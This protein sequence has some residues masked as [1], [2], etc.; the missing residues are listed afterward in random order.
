[1]RDWQRALHTAHEVMPLARDATEC[2]SE[3]QSPEEQGNRGRFKNH[4]VGFR[5]QCYWLARGFFVAFSR[6]A[7]P[8]RE[9]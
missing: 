6:E 7:R 3:L 5:G 8:F 9:G 2:A 1:M 4:E